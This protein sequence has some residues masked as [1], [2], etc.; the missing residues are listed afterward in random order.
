MRPVHDTVFS[1]PRP[2]DP[3]DEPEA[4]NSFSEKEVSPPLYMGPRRSLRGFRRLTNI[5]V[6]PKEFYDEPANELE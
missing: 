1:M 2:E 6:L 5:L 3:N 4:H